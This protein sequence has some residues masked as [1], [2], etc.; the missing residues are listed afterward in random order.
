M[1]GN[2]QVED[3]VGEEEEDI[4]E[5]EVLDD[6]EI[7]EDDDS[8][9]NSDDDEK[10]SEDDYENI[11]VDGKKFSIP[12]ELKESFLRHSDYTRK[13][14]E[15]GEQRRQHGE[16]VEAHQ[17]EQRL[18]QEHQQKYAELHALNGQI[19]QYQTVDWQTLQ[20]QN[21]SLAQEH[22]FNFV[23]L[24]NDAQQK[25]QELE[26]LKTHSE[27]TQRG[28]S[29]KRK[30]EVMSRLANEVEGWSGE[31]A[32]AV[33]KTAQKMGFTPQFLKAVNEAVFPDTVSM[34][35][36]LNNAALYEEI[37]AKAKKAGKG[38]KQVVKITPTKKVGRGNASRKS[39]YDTKLT[40]E[41]RVSLR[42]K[43]RESSGK[44]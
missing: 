27:E 34:V 5:G 32:Q 37:V 1:E 21:P 39:I 11:E 33:A 35:K 12:K 23:N 36:A 19:E 4:I 6:D 43:Q 2:D 30:S 26:T 40:T 14:Q 41:Q 16:A 28:N 38:G 13:T 25:A 31:R 29:A 7:E 18:Y 15:V 42:R 9:V 10:E 44:K 24:K 3:T 17:A 22:Q 20:A 8:N